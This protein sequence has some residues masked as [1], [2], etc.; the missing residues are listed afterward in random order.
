MK[1]ISFLASI[2][3]IALSTKSQ[4]TIKIIDSLTLE[5]LHRATISLIDGKTD[6]TNS[7]GNLTVPLR[8][9]EKNI[10]KISAIGYTAK[11]IS[12]DTLYDYVIKLSKSKVF[13]P[14][15]EINAVRAGKNYPFTQSMISKKE[16]G[17]KNLGQDI[18]ILLNQVPGVVVNSDAGNGIGYTGMR[19]RGTDATRINIT[20][21]GIPYN[22]AESQGVYFVNLPDLISSTNSIQ[23]QRGVGTSSNGTGSFGGTINILTNEVQP[24]PYATLSKSYGSYNSNKNTVKAGTGLINDQYTF[25]IRLS[26]I[27]SNGYIDRSK[28]DLKSFFISAASIK[29]KSSFRLNIFSGKEK[30]YQA[31]YGITEDQLTSNR[32]ENSAGTEKPGTPYDNETDNYTQ[33]HYQAFY[34]KKINS[35]WNFNNA[36]YLTKG[37]GYYEQYKADQEFSNYG[38]ANPK[39][40]GI[41]IHATDLIRQLWLSNQ[42]IGN[43]LSLQFKDEHKEIMIG[44]GISHYHGNHFGK[45]IWSNIG[46]P[47]EY[48]WYDLTANKYESHFFTKWLQKLGSNTNLFGDIQ[49]RDVHYKINGFRDNPSLFINKSWTFINPKMG[50]SKKLGKYNL[51]LSYA[52]ANK[53]PNRDDFE[54][55]LTQQ[56]KFEK[57]GD[58]EMGIERVAGVNKLSVTAYYMNYTNQLILTGKINDVGAYTRSNVSKSFRAGIELE[59][60][61]TILKWLRIDNNLSLSKN[62]IKNY[63]EYYDDYDAG[64]Q[65]SNFY[66]KS[67][68]SFSPSIIGN[69]IIKL[70]ISKSLHLN[71]TSKYVSRQY[72]DNTSR[73]DR[74]LNPYFIQDL[75][76]NHQLR[77]K[78]TKSIDLSIQLNNIWNK[79]YEPNGYTYSY[80]Y[81]GKISKNNFYFPMAGTNIMAGITINF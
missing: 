52:M 29:E 16:I 69:S 71:L 79:L 11:L 6:F 25:D 24:L 27:N 1:K 66:Q 65:K 53:E 48:T 81:E 12:T 36:S 50:L 7:D 80:L 72:L 4:I 46:I 59:G 64:E 22:D 26:S 40:D 44:G 70:D 39:I 14:P 28:S 43:N 74:S 10:L 73:K 63:T 55:G 21:N 78:N 62:K 68:I 37:D 23:V 18:P 5:P 49:V 35:N 76:I 33:T 45:V 75:Q 15:I 34:N 51:Y 19:I 17:S 32:R 60:N 42:L 8:K 56:P 13:M 2:F 9:N 58:Y 77:F 61:L 54:S 20:L 67:D 31:W 38:L 3:L 47:K 41:E 57:L 30:T